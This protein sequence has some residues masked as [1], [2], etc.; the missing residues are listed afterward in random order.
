MHVFIVLQEYVL[1]LK[2]FQTKHFD[3]GKMAEWSI[4][5]VLKTVDLKGFGGSNP[6]LSAK[7]KRF[8]RCELAHRPKKSF[9]FE[10]GARGGVRDSNVVQNSSLS[11]KKTLRFLSLLNSKSFLLLC[12]Y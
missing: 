7:K 11:A 2:G 1:S 6:S 8:L 5:A 12:R 3:Y 9:F 4:A 10:H